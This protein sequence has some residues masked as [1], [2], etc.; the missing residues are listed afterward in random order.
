[1][2]A[3]G[4]QDHTAAGF[5]RSVDALNFEFFHAG[6]LRCTLYVTGMTARPA[7]IAPATAARCGLSAIKRFSRRGCQREG[8]ANL[9]GE[10]A[11]K[12]DLRRKLVGCAS[13]LSSERRVF[14]TCRLGQSQ[15]LQG[16]IRTVKA[17]DSQLRFH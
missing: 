16:A 10:L 12:R 2:Y 1:M 3:M 15:R 9:A 14:A 6:C 7:C 8:E 13:I 4:Q 5:G 11:A 17:A